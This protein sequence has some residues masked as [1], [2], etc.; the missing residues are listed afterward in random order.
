MRGYSFY[1]LAVI[2]AIASAAGGYYLHQFRQNPID[3]G[4][5]Q[6]AIVFEIG[7]R[8]PE[9]ALPDLEGQ[10]HSIS[11]WDGKVL[12]INFWA[13]WCPPCVRE[14]PAFQEIYSDY[15]TQNVEVI[16][17]ALDEP[18]YIREFLLD[19]EVTYTQLHGQL[20]VIQLMSMLGNKYGTLPYTVA[21]NSAG[22]IAAIASAGELDYAQIQALLDPLLERAD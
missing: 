4:H 16:G 20:E 10:Y 14:I 18:Q 12:L 7:D 3:S 15:R 1:A 8:R 19:K 11:Q 9:F 22:Q 5:Q 21:L 6:T 13:S 2:L 17:I